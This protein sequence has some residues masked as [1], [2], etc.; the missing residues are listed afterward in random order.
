MT[1]N[2]R[3]APADS[4]RQLIDNNNDDND[5][6]DDDELHHNLPFVFTSGICLCYTTWWS[7][8]WINDRMPHGE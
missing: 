6:N 5:D 4:S 1:M 3:H 7:E 2:K 8:T